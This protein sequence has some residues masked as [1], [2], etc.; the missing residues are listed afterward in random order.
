[1]S[2]TARIL[3]LLTKRKLMGVYNYELNRICF[4]YSAR[5]YDLRKEGY[6]IVSEQ[7]RSGVWRYTLVDNQL[8][9]N[10]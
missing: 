2:K 7:I 10:V 1:M 8:Q 5:I 3:D 4:R 6:S 9:G